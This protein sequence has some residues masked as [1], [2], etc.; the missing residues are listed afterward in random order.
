MSDVLWVSGGVRD[1]L[2]R[3]STSDPGLARLAAGAVLALLDQGERLGPPLLVPM[4]GPASPRE[5]HPGEALD[6]TYQRLLE[7]LT[8][9]RRG[10]ADVATSRKRLELQLSSSPG[11]HADELAARHAELTAAEERLTT[12]SQLMMLRVRDF[13]LRKETL[14]AQYTAAQSLGLANDALATLGTE[15]DDPAEVPF[16]GVYEAMARASAAAGELL[17]AARDL[18]DEL[19]GGAA[20]A[21]PE[22]GEPEPG[23]PRLL[24]LRPAA[25]GCV[26][27]R[28]LC[29]V[30][31][32]PVA[33]GDGHAGA[34][35]TVLLAAATDHA[36]P[37]D[38]PDPLE[39]QARARYWAMLAADA[40]P[41]PGLAAAPGAPAA[42]DRASFA[43]AFLPGV[44]LAADDPAPAQ[45]A[46]D[47]ARPRDL[48]GLRAR[49]GL[50]QAQVAQ[51][52]G[53]RQ[54]RVSALERGDLTAA[55]ARTLAAY[56]AALGG[57]LE[58]TAEFG[59]SRVLLG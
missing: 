46:A 51:R 42:Y 56:V 50:T 38:E 27:V 52:L 28:I 13:R 37:L 6:T 48:A 11:P 15:G 17:D 16:P 47:R 20:P 53:V 54:E 2:T 45:A 30:P 23:E 22:P 1:W 44:G 55:E 59:T 36:R 26:A 40:A 5:A 35:G 58:L 8:G 21:A 4:A 49:A 29:A 34:P 41:E 33:A 7:L 39:G 14:K 31:D 24:I 32:Q 18:G 43:S 57:R 9:L 19:R 3:L 10:V 12:E 25:P